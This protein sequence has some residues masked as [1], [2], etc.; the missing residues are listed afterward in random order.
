[1]STVLTDDDDFRR[2]LLGHDE[3]RRDVRAVE[4][5][6]GAGCLA[7]LLNQPLFASGL[8][9]R[10]VLPALDHLGRGTGDDLV[11]AP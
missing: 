7:L 5:D 6:R 1:M 4:P 11:M 10:G 8:L 2:V 9:P 3:I